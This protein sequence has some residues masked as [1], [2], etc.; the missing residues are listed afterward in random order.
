MTQ[1]V[2][3]LAGE[4]SGDLHAARVVSALAERMPDLEIEAVGGPRM[5]R[6]GATIR[7][8]IDGLSAMGFVE[9]L[10][11]LPAH[12]RLLRELTQQF[13]AGRYDLVIV[14]DYPGFHLR[15]A[16]AAQSAGIPVLGYVAPQLWA[17]HPGRADKW[18][19][20][21]DRLAVILP[22]ET[23]FFRTH[24]IDATYVGHPLL[25]EHEHDRVEP[26][27]ARQALG[28]PADARVLALFPG[29]RDG[30][31]RRLWPVYRDAARALVATGRAQ[32]V[33]IA[34]TGEASYPGA[35]GML[36]VRDHTELV[37]AAADAAL[38][39]SGTTT[40]QAALADVP[41]VVAY[42]THPLTY[43]L[44]RHLITVPWVS[45]VNLVGEREIV[46]ELV[47]S[48]VTAHALAAA[49]APLLEAGHPAACEQRRGLAEVRARL[50]EAGASHR[51]ADLAVDLLAG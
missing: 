50:G 43:Q 5:A 9:I 36:I 48:E 12:W 15:V 32:H 28:I 14:V 23:E 18:A 11:K 25:D 3:V 24:G 33:V 42:R 26:Q 16:Q 4:P 10:H 8:S 2:L 6:A 1:R 7:R 45:L 27:Q 47:Q 17:W 46:P 34:G 19:R 31:I 41:M 29:S 13:R 35:E 40:L 22:F 30:E 39:K 44:A 49:T 38:V 37:L 51:V 21:V 20:A